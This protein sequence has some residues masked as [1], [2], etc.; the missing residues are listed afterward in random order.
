MVEAV[1]HG[2]SIRAIAEARGI[3]RDAV[4]FHIVNA[5][6]KLGL[7]RRARLRRW[8]CTAHATL[9]AR[10]AK[11]I[12]APHLNHRHPNGTEG[13]LAMLEDPRWPPAGDLVAAEG[14]NV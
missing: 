8:T 1:R 7:D 11:F 10:G 6:V 9:E 5:L 14:V 3:S 13:W 12:N 2:H 4:K